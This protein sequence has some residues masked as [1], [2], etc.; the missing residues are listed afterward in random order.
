[1]NKN[2]KNYTEQPDPNVWGKIENTLRRRALLRRWT[3]IGAGAAAVAALVVTIAIL[4]PTAVETCVVPDVQQVAQVNQQPIAAQQTTAVLTSD[5]P[6]QSATKVTT[7]VQQTA[8]PTVEAP[9]PSVTEPVSTA[10]AIVEAPAVTTSTTQETGNVEP[11]NTQPMATI[12]LSTDEITLPEDGQTV[13]E[14]KPAKP[15]DKAS[16][17]S[18]ID[19]TILWIPNAFAPNSD[20]ESITLFR[21]RLSHPGESISDYRMAIF[22]R[23][24]MQVF[25]TNS[26]NQAW[27]GTYK[28][29]PLPQG[30]YVYVIYYT[31]KDNMRHQRKGTVTLIR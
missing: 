7:A 3:R 10:P 31:D 18:T 13:A 4:N 1:M 12:A 5:N 27:N 21:P 17:N 29:R 26:L 9:T 19:D 6:D 16:T 2:L 20:D 25:T 24:G 15:A 14:T 30:A 22:N 28:G 8:V 11:T 23:S